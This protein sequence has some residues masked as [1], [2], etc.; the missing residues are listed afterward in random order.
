MPMTSTDFVTL[1]QLHS[2]LH[3]ATAWYEA[4]RDELHCPDPTIATRIADHLLF[5]DFGE[6]RRWDHGIQ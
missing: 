6:G 1:E 4:I 5:S 3:L 2:D